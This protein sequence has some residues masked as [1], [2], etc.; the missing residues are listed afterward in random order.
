MCFARA[1][2]VSVAWAAGSMRTV[3]AMVERLGVEAS[4]LRQLGCH[5]DRPG[6]MPTYLTPV[7]GTAAGAGAAT[8]RHP[9]RQRRRGCGLR[10]GPNRAPS[11]IGR[12]LQDGGRVE[13][14]PEG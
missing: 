7:A 12:W 8:G 13:S 10:A 1:I 5:G 2:S 4:E 9:R 6:S 14:T 3:S 11:V